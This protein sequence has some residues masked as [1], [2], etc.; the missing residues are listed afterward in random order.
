MRRNLNQQETY[1]DSEGSHAHN[2]TSIELRSG[3]EGP[4]H[5]PYGYKEI[6]VTRAD[7]REATLH[8]GLA[9]WLV[10]NDGRVTRRFEDP[11]ATLWS[12]FEACVGISPELAER[13]FHRIKENRIRHHKCGQKYLNEVSGYPG[14]T[15]LMCEKCKMILDSSFNEAAII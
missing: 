12:K 1:R 15:F 9:E 10:Y 11:I 4:A 8:S 7:G 2:G 3:S 6:T 5:D 14:E 13:T